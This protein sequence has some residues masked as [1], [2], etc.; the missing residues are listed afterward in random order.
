MRTCAST[1]E[2]TTKATTNDGNDAPS[3]ESGRHNPLIDQETDQPAD[4]HARPH[5]HLTG[6]TLARPASES[7]HCRGAGGFPTAELISEHDREQRHEQR[8][9]QEQECFVV[10][11]IDHRG[12]G[13]RKDRHRDRSRANRH[14]PGQVRGAHANRIDICERVRGLAGH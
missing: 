9:K 5:R 12:D 11:K 4:D 6:P 3:H 7:R 13:Y 8:A 10:T 1:I 2:A 14:L